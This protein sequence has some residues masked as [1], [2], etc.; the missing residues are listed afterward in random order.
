MLKK[1][2]IKSLGFT[3]ISVQEMATDSF[4]NTFTVDAVLLE[5]TV[6]KYNIMLI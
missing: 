6:N 3:I 5:N 4:N 1:S 2:A